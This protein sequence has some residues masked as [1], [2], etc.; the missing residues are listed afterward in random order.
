MDKSNIERTR[1]PI[2]ASIP[3][4]EAR[5]WEQKPEMHCSPPD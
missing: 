2:A 1:A 3:L 5:S 4:N